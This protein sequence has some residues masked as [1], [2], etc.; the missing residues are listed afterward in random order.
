M[1]SPEI[2]SQILSLVE[3]ETGRIQYGKIMIEIT[4]AKG[5]CT[6][7]QAET[8]RSLNLNEPE[9]PKVRFNSFEKKP[10]SATLE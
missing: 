4:V 9:P 1:I 10:G 5:K 6:N 7:I 8:K 3:E 2:K